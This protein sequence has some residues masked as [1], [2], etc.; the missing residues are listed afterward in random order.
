MAKEESMIIEEQ[1]RLIADVNQKCRS[2]FNQ[3]CDQYRETHS[4]DHAVVRDELDYLSRRHDALLKQLQATVQQSKEQ[5][6]N[7]S[8]TQQIENSLTNGLTELSG[9]IHK[10]QTEKAQAILKLD[11]V[12]QQCLATLCQA[13]RQAWSSESSTLFAAPATAGPVGDFLIASSGKITIKKA[14]TH[15]GHRATALTGY[16]TGFSTIM[17]ALN[18]S[19]PPVASQAGLVGHADEAII[20]DAKT[21]YGHDVKQIESEKS[22]QEASLNTTL[23]L[24]QTGL[25][26]P[27]KKQWTSTGL[28]CTRFYENHQ[29]YYE[30]KVIFGDFENDTHLDQ[31][32]A[33]LQRSKLGACSEKTQ[34]QGN[35]IKCIYFTDADEVKTLYK[36]VT[37]LESSLTSSSS[38]SVVLNY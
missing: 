19:P 24:H 26:K 5:P 18:A 27:P 37:S 12:S 33:I 25:L 22:K 31:V 28:I 21:Y 15:I 3:I 8:L 13:L 9:I 14:E 29:K 35:H 36:K 1:I 32:Q 10:M 6:W 34:M 17:S 20:E 30:I 16:E 2:L 7:P 4:A 11:P 38:S 23:A